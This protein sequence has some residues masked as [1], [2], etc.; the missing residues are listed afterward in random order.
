MD[1][2]RRCV[3]RGLLTV[4]TTVVAGCSSYLNNP[5]SEISIT[6]VTE[7][8]T[9]VSI[10]IYSLPERTTVIDEGFVLEPH[11]SKEYASPFAKDGK[12]RIEIWIDENRNASYEWEASDSDST[13]LAVTVYENRISINEI[14][15]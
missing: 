1:R 15:P 10:Q 12:K 6:N 3:L 11:T 7:Q 4:T 14:S 9:K 8:E 2:A 13:G 5:V